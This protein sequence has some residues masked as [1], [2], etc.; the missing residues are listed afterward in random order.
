[1][2]AHKPQVAVTGSERAPMSGAT[3]V[4]PSSPDERLEVT[5]RLRPRT[6]LQALKASGVVKEH[7]QQRRYLSHA[8]WAATYGAAPEDIAKVEAFAQAHGLAVVA[9][10]VPRRSV[11]LSGTVAAFGAAFGVTLEQYDHPDGSYRG[12][13]GT[14]KVPADLAD[15]VQGVFGL[16]NRPQ[17]RPHFQV[18]KS[19]LA[20]AAQDSQSFTPVQIDK[21]YN[22]PSNLDGSGQ[23]I[24][25]IELGGGY[26]PA[27]IQK[28]FTGLGLAAPKV[29]TVSVD[30]G[31][32]HPT[33]PDSADGEVMLDIEVTAAVAPKATVAV[34]FA[35]NTD[36][37][38]L[39]A[40]TKAV[41]D[42]VNK[43][44]VVSISWGSAEANWTAQAMQA[45][46]EAFQAAA[47]LG[48][49]ICVAA[50]D[51]GS[52][53]GESDGKTHVDFPASSP[54][55]LGCG[56]TKLVASGGTVTSETVWNESSDSATGGGVSVTF[57]RPDY[58]AKAAVPAPSHAGGG[59]GVP[60]V[61]GDAD[62]NSGYQVRVDGKGLVIGGTSAVAPLMAGLVALL[63]QG[64]GHPVGFLNPVIYS[65]KPG[66]GAFRDITV[67][68]N[69]KFSAK[70][71]W[72]ACTGLGVADGSR[73]LQ[74]LQQ[75]ANT[76][77]S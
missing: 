20:A 72:D 24:A 63:N 47:A 54:F 7:P 73:L 77:V 3:A 28:Y 8:E 34:Y 64:L 56:G 58:Q 10:D 49:T 65:L 1:M 35:P 74:A 13:V 67:G 66:S 41:H 16:D 62:P 4:G 17:A 27:D 52:A 29:L 25:L 22:Y 44:S 21:L 68:N 48:V 57:P 38:F 53:D 75:G 12:R 9:T 71:G 14:V 51:N 50:G 33:T 26:K 36:Q 40:V 45:M 70:S 32:N 2:T 59:R 60:D 46:D 42:T 6:P 39:D 5:V 55:A 37:G 23:C 11:H 30:G 19:P 43:P 15:V 61:A 31:R 76:A 69:G 18:K